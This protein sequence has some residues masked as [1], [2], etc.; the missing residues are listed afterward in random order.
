VGKIVGFTEK[1]QK[2]VLTQAIAFWDDATY[3]MGPYF[4]FVNEM[5]R[6]T[7]VLLPKELETQLAKFPDRAQLVP[8]DI[9][10]NLASIKAIIRRTVFRKKPYFP[11]EIVGEYN[12]ADPRVEKAE[13]ILQ[14][15]MDMEAD[16]KGFPH[17]AAKAV[18]QAIYAGLTVVVTR[19]HREYGKKLVRNKDFSPASVAPYPEHPDYVVPEMRNTIIAEYPESKSLDVRRTR[20]DPNAGDFDNIS[21]IGYQGQRQLYDLIALNRNKLTHYQ[22]DEK[23]LANSTFDKTQYYEHVPQEGT[24]LPSSTS[25][26]DTGKYGDKPIE[27]F[28]IRGLFR[29]DNADLTTDIRDLIVEVGN[30]SVLMALKDNDLPLRGTDLFDFPRIED[31]H[32]RMYAMGLVEAGRD[33]F[34]EMVL[35]RNQS[36]DSAN[37][38]V[39]NTYLADSSAALDVP[40][41]VESANDQVYKLDL[42]SAGLIDVHHAM[43]VLERPQLGQDTFNHAQVLA[44]ELQQTHFVNDYV[45][46]KDPARSETATGVVALTSGPASLAEDLIEIL[47]DTYFTPVSL[48]KLKLWVFFKG[49]KL[50]KVRLSDGTRA[51]VTLEDLEL[52]YKVAVRNS[53][54]ANDAARQRRV[55]ES[56]P[57]LMNDPFYDQFEFRRMINDVLELPGGSKLLKHPDTARRYP[58][59]ESFALGYGMD[60][61]VH[62][63][64]NH[65]LHKDVH[66]EYRQY[67]ESQRPEQL[68]AQGITLDK[69]IAHEERH[70]MEMQSQEL[71]LG[72]SKELGGA[73]G[74]L[75]QPEGSRHKIKPTGAAGEYLPKANRS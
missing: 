20:I 25:E 5:E 19:W 26:A 43:A 18:F 70:D 28:S 50:G 74:N 55:V 44:R 42:A 67:L 2:Q 61:E 15:I 45:Q 6:L 40:D 33:L 41:V 62:P 24:G 60:S 36:L 56:M 23:E 48:K 13:Q 73:S 52:P 64:D 69:L 22:F 30:R 12:A 53:I 58:D 51:A 10:N 7:R 11:L 37:R 49:H 63:T 46:G 8:P 32:G 31:Q 1:Q 57:L 27:T 35:K 14:M 71:A 66:S 68:A 59:L 54:N 47:N 9:R 21:I 17:E 75:S 39:H 3:K 16:G 34:V 65:R 72:N 4:N 38:N 29:V